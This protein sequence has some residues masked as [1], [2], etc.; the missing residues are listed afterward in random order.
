MHTFL[1]PAH[2]CTLLLGVAL[3]L[4]SVPRC[5]HPTFSSSSLPI[6]RPHPI[7]PFSA[8]FPNYIMRPVFHSQNSTFRTFPDRIKNY[9]FSASTIYSIFT[10]SAGLQH[11]SSFNRH[12]SLKRIILQYI[13]LFISRTFLPYFPNNFFKAESASTLM[14]FPKIQKLACLHTHTHTK[15]IGTPLFV[16]PPSCLPHL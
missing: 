8:F 3:T 15:Y 13:L 10:A 7:G 6:P 2:L 16:P 11:D 9:E 12:Y 1:P 4:V 14:K 5:V